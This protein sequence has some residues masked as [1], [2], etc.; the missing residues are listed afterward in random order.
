LL[1]P[2]VSAFV[3]MAENSPTKRD[4]LKQG[5]VNPCQAM[6]FR[7]DQQFTFHAFENLFYVRWRRVSRIRPEL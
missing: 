7:I 6:Y 2:E 5:A 4:L 1:H 3:E